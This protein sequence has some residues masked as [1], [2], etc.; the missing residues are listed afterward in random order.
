MLQRL[1]HDLQPG[2][3]LVIV[4]QQEGPLRDWVPFERREEEHH[5]TGETT[6][7]RLAREAGFLFHDALDDLWHERQP[8]VP[9][10]PRPSTA[11]E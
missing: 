2:G 4:D 8:F 9:F 1:W 6:V 7:V 5:W 3:Y 11:T 10:R